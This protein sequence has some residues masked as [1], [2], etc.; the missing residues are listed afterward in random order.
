MPAYQDQQQARPAPQKQALTAQDIEAIVRM[1]NVEDRL[2]FTPDD[3][4]MIWEICPAPCFLIDFKRFIRIASIKKL[5]PLMNDLHLEYRSDRKSPTGLKA[6]IV[7]HQDGLL[8]VAHRTT[9]LDGITQAN[10]KD[11]R[12]WFVDSTVFKKGSTHPFTFRAYYHEFVA[13]EYG[14]Q[15]PTYMW[16]KSPY[17]M[18]AKCSR[19]GALRIAF[20]EELSGIMAE[21]EMIESYNQSFPDATPA[22][23]TPE[24]PPPTFTIGEKIGEKIGSPAPEPWPS[25]VLPP[26]KGTPDR[27][28]APFDIKAAAPVAVQPAA[29]G[30]WPP[31]GP[32]IQPTPAVVEELSKAKNGTQ[33][34]KADEDPRAQYKAR[35]VTLVGTESTYAKAGLKKAHIDKMLLG[36]F[37][38]E[39][40][41]QLPK[42]AAEYPPILDILLKTLAK[43][44]GYLTYLLNEPLAYGKEMKEASAAMAGKA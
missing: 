33:K 4:G 21:E 43:G 34:T 27:E 19:A 29:S 30:V 36:W 9:L 14:G 18:T 39:K 1:T 24:P 12:G 32:V 13:I 2:A 17:N 25:P 11:E 10:G 16:S 42:D 15:N 35:L 22:T 7:I 20:P 26:V 41:S 8:K 23:S 6:S 37:G 38:I 31:P 28:E 44:E 40:E 3:I 5:D